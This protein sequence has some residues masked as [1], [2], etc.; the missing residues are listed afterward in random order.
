[1]NSIAPYNFSMQVAWR[2]LNLLI[3]RKIMLH[4]AGVVFYV[5]Q[6]GD[7]I[8]VAFDP[9][10]IQL[11]R[12]NDEF[13]HA[14]STRLHG[15]RVVRTNS[16][17]IFL[18]VGFETPAAP[19]PLEAKPLDLTQQPTEWH[20]PIGLTKDGPLWISLIEG[21]SFL[22]GGSRRKGK[23]GL[24]H[25][26]IQALLNGGRTQVYAW[27]G[28]GGAE[29]QG[30]IGRTNFHFVSNAERGLKALAEQ[31]AER[32]NQLRVSG[33]PNIIMHNEAGKDFIQPIAFI[34]DEI[35]ELEDHLK[36][37]LKRMVKLYGASGL[38]PVLATND[39]TQAAIL[40]K[41]N[42]ST[43]ICFAVPSFQDSL[44][45]LGM[46]G[47]ESLTE[48]GRGL[49]IWDR[50]LT[51]FQTFQ[52]SYPET[53]DEQRRL[54]SEQVAM[55]ITRPASALMDE[56][57][58]LAESIRGRWSLGMSLNK[59]SDLLGKSYEG[60]SW[61]RKVKQVVEFLTTTTTPPN[62]LVSGSDGA[63]AGS[64]SSSEKE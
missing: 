5:W 47:A 50:G 6:R 62:A 25:G 7:R 24:T 32:L 12:V 26:M 41:T 1:M 2:T 27:D 60:S 64:S 42:L 29:Y 57:E 51:E 21:D 40:V 3:E 30:Y 8:I 36:E 31:L 55:E 45:V 38:Y 37:Q 14:L 18:Q 54:L 17:G 46:K 23:S 49:V 33:Y 48:R 52:V 15:R 11:E 59:V 20:M 10:A 43:R 19:Q 63:V 13:A 44:T 4:P 58:R 22:I 39:P 34:V 53:T 9:S 28:K 56:I 61:T 16:R 35:A